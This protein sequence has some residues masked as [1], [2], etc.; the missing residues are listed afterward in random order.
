[1]IS[2]AVAATCYRDFPVARYGIDALHV[3]PN[4]S[5]H[6]GPSN[7]RGQGLQKHF[8]TTS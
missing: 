4:Q 6:G 3:A 5:L 7:Q 1:M 2:N 8:S